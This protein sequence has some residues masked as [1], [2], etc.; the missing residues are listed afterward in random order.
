MTVTDASGLGLRIGE[1][2]EDWSGDARFF[3]YSRAANPIGSG[4]TPRIPIESF[5]SRLHKGGATRI[6]PLDLSAALGIE[7]GPA[8]S[9]AL[10][11]SFIHIRADEKIS[12]APN[13][14]SE[15]YFVLRG[16]GL[17]IV[18]GEVVTWGAGDFLTLPAGCRSTHHA[19]EDAAIYWVTD[20]PLLRFLGVRA[21]EARFRATKYEA[22][23]VRAELAKVAASPRASERSR[24]SVLLANANQ[25]QT[26]TATH[27]LWAMFGL[28]PAHSS[29]RPHRHQSVAL[30]LCLD[31]AEGSYTLLGNQLDGDGSIVDPVRVDWS[32]GSAFVTP[33]G[34]WHAHFNESDRDAL[35]IPVQ[36]AG[37]QTYLRA[38][39]I[40]FAP[41]RSDKAARSGAAGA[42]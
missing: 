24:I 17:S 25:P 29:Q 27:V 10:L 18:D 11:A 16:A 40:R 36:D 33:P 7:S 4:Y 35:I 13:A 30:D 26:L 15:L 6:V 3:E 5:S 8:T 14:T 1:I 37:L 31:C 2:S 34:M 38:L 28:V 32:P 21:T 9:P 12:T 20:E 22:A 41:P 19:T 39:D 23:V 42:P